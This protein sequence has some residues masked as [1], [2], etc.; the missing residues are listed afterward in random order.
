MYDHPT[1][2]IIDWKFLDMM[3]K[4]WPP[5]V[6]GAC[7][8]LLELSCARQMLEIASL[9]MVDSLCHSASELAFGGSV[10]TSK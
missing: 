9:G 3:K 2:S 6:S 8:N 10:I 1:S 4:T 7:L 5:G